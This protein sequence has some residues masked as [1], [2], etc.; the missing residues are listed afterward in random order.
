MKKVILRTQFAYS[1]L[2]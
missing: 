1:I 2:V